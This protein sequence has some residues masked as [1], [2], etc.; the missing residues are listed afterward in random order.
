MWPCWDPAVTSLS[1]QA[2]AL[3][4]C[5]FLFR[6]R[7]GFL[8]LLAFECAIAPSLYWQQSW[9]VPRATW[10]KYDSPAD[11]RVWRHFPPTLSS[12]LTRIQIYFEV[13]VRLSSLLT[14]PRAIVRL[15]T[16]NIH[17]Y[18]AQFYLLEESHFPCHHPESPHFNRFCP[19]CG[20]MVISDHHDKF[21]V[22]LNVCV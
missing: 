18:V 3:S 10:I 17:H 6:A 22:R 1:L 20:Q 15:C 14:S 2:F 4:G 11:T 16:T 12:R 19:L 9:I 13:R 7:S 8:L 21:M 5:K